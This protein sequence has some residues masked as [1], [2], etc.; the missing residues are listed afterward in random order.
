MSICMLQIY[1]FLHEDDL[2]QP[3]EEINRCIF[4]EINI[5]GEVDRKISRT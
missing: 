4:D 5:W 2:E 1:I 3:Y